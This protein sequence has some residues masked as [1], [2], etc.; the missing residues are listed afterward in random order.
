[1]PPRSLKRLDTLS[2]PDEFDDQKTP[3]EILTAETVS[4]THQDLVNFLLSQIRQIT[5]EANWFDP[6]NFSIAQIKVGIL[7]ANCL[8]ADSV[9]K[10]V[11]ITGNEVAGKIQVTTSDLADPAKMPVVGVIIEKSSSTDALVQ[12]VGEVPP[13]FT[14]LT[15]NKILY[16][17]PGGDPADSIPIASGDI[18]QRIG[19]AIGVERML[20]IP[21]FGLT[22]RR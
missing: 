15:P 18:V 3:A 20:I 7:P 17:G 8:A 11:Y 2:K 16:A 9:G 14:G 13:I 5:G 12:Y 22:R 4:V 19:F 1:M 10:T 6:P 21:D